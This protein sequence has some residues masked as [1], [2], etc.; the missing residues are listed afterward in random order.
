MASGSGRTLGAALVDLFAG[1]RA[2]GVRTTYDRVGWRAQFAQLSKTKAGYA[3][4]EAAGLEATIRT[5]RGWLAGDTVPT[6]ANQ[7][8]IREAYRSMAGGFGRQWSTA[9]YAIK[10]RLTQGRDSRVRGERGTSPL[11]L[12]GRLG[13]WDRIEDAWT[14]GEPDPG[15]IERLFIQDVVVPNLG[16]GSYP[17]EF[18][19]DWYEV[20]A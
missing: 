11:R 1:G 20:N 4:M 2:A 6:A 8:K 3:A 19:G 16:E 10:G 14:D 13:R 7:A 12:D 5:Q 9:Q 18:D 15:E 17:W